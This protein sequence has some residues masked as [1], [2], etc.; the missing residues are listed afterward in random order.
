MKEHYSR[1][2][3]FFT[4]LLILGSFF[5]VVSPVEA[6]ADTDIA[7]ELVPNT[8]QL[9]S[10][11]EQTVMLVINNTSVNEISNLQVTY[12][13]D[14]I[15]KINFITSFTNPIPP[16][17]SLALQLH[18]S[19]LATVLEKETI[20]IKV[21]FIE[22]SPQSEAEIHKIQ[23]LPLQITTVSEE[24]VA[25]PLIITT[26]ISNDTLQ[27][28]QT[29][30]IIVNLKNSLTEPVEVQAI[31]P[32]VDSNITVTQIDNLPIVIAPG[33]GANVSFNVSINSEGAFQSGEYPILFTIN[34]V[35][36][37]SQRQVQMTAVQTVTL[38]VVGESDLMKLLGIPSFLVLP[39]F[40]IVTTILVLYRLFSKKAY[41]NKAVAP[42]FWLAAISL[43][44]GLFFIYKPLTF[45][46][47][48]MQILS[49]E[50]DFLSGYGLTDLLVVWIISIL[51]GIVICVLYYLLKLIWQGIKR[52]AA[53]IFTFSGEESE[54]DFLK[55]QTRRFQDFFVP[56]VEVISD[57]QTYRGWQVE[58]DDKAKTS[59]IC[60]RLKLKW[61]SPFY[62]KKDQIKDLLQK[63]GFISQYQLVNLIEKAESSG[64]VQIKWDEMGETKRLIKITGV[65]KVTPVGNTESL[66]YIGD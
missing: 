27:E 58:Y 35:T 53:Y 11:T 65:K 52:L 64:Q 38:G 18:I 3:L 28:K 46:L 8:L 63:K 50:R 17:G 31:A 45:L 22:K 15:I 61:Q 42:E 14:S 29:D 48:K 25:D 19:R 16:G 2:F 40:L 55:K 39:G 56:Q 43:S 57:T 21:D 13:P 37:Y 1:Y 23:I 44:I 20:Y 34:G 7:M 51:I 47:T 54:L 41:D 36:Q 5:L 26:F 60:S 32:L 30:S 10:S 62:E 66:I 33:N 9:S 12:Y 24:K 59:V 6:G 4:I 49:H